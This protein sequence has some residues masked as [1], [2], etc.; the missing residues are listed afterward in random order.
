MK[1]TDLTV[2][3][4]DKTLA[5]Q[6][7][8]RPEELV[9][10]LEDAFNNVGTWKLTLAAEHPLVGHLRTPGSGLIITGPSDVLM[11][12]PTVKYESAATP[13]DPGGSVVFEG[14]SD[15]CILSDRLVFPTAGHADPA[16]MPDQQMTKQGRVETIMH[17][18]VRD[19]IGSGAHS[20]R[21]VANLVNGADGARG[22]IVTK[23]G[24]YVV[25]GNLLSE[26]AVVASLGFRIV[27]RG[28]Q[29]VFE[30][31]QVTNRSS[32]IRLDVGNGTLGG[33]RVA[34]TP[35]SATRAIVA[36]VAQFTTA[37]STA[38]ES[39][40]GRVIETFSDQSNADSSEEVKQ[41]GMEILAD[42]GF[43]SVAVQAVPVDD[44]SMNFGTDWYMGDTVSVVAGGQEL[45]STVTGMI[46]KAT[47]DGF[48]IGALLGDATG[49]DAGAAYAKRVQST[50]TRV[51]RLEANGA[52][53]GSADAIYNIMG[54]W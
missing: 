17:Q 35:P 3:V 38:A 7:V 8:I 19:Q 45:S 9:M 18:F 49:F 1:L 2:E 5:R 21:R 13:E 34:V 24:R 47:S 43:T 10:E 51:S 16:T 44:S 41:T 31:Y 11:S 30:T 33:Q 15:T 40:W 52:S 28:A 53:G 29:L 4:R 22:D 20:S 6:G 26:L 50:E 12:G 23:S 54:V 27:Q 37:E 14:V 36:G 32:Y 25:L 48:N 42:R 46:L 39:E